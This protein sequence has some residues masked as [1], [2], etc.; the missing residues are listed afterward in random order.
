[1][2]SKLLQSF[3]QRTEERLL[4]QLISADHFLMQRINAQ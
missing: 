4:S 2:E 3:R 1:M